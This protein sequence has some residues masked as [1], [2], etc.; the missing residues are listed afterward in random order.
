[1]NIIEWFKRLFRI[2]HRNAFTKTKVGEV[3]IVTDIPEVKEL[4]QS[5]QQE[6]DD[7][8]K[9]LV[10]IGKR[11]ETL[12]REALESARG[13]RAFTRGRSIAKQLKIERIRRMNMER[14]RSTLGH[15]LSGK[16]FKPRSAFEKRTWRLDKKADDD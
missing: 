5:K 11:I 15:G 1:M 7:T 6:I 12:K 4:A 3:T 13:S 10:A 2:K 16:F 9:E 8:N 14:Q